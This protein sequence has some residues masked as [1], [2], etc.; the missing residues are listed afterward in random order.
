MK[1]RGRRSAAVR[2]RTPPAFV[3]P[4]QCKP[5]TALPAGEN[6]VF[7]LKLDGYRCIAAKRGKEVTVEYSGSTFICTTPNTNS[8]PVPDAL[9]AAPKGP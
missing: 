3:E 4:M 5:V 8:P 7:E 6:W 2:N 1:S 9:L